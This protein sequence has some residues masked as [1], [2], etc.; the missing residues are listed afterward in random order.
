MEQTTGCKVKSY[1]A[2][3][4]S[5]VYTLPTHF[6]WESSSASGHPNLPYFFEGHPK[7][8][9]AEEEWSYDDITNTLLIWMPSCADPNA[10]T[11][12]G[13]VQDVSLTVKRTDLTLSG[14]KLFGTTFSADTTTLNFDKV[15]FD[16]PTWNKRSIGD[17]TETVHTSLVMSSTN[18]LTMKDSSVLYCDGPYFLA[19]IGKH[20]VISN[21]VFKGRN[22]NPDPDPSP[23]PNPDD[24]KGTCYGTGTSATVTSR[25]GPKYLTFDSNTV[26]HYHCLGGVLP[27]NYAQITN[28]YFT[29][30]GVYLDGAAIHIQGCLIHTPCPPPSVSPNPSGAAEPMPM[31]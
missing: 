27:H 3:N 8:L 12:R 1:N 14:I 20:A 19:K 10:A 29:E 2:D 26:S 28:N 25:N 18:T 11:I 24:S 22:P 30:Q 7:L 31:E 4:E 6:Q 15:T 23:N 13:R 21:S 5:L 17:Q 9:D 16:F